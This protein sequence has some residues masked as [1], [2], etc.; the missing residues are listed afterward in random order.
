VLG[1][2]RD[3]SGAVNVT[4][5]GPTGLP[6]VSAEASGQPSERVTRTVRPREEVRVSARR[7]VV[8][9]AVGWVLIPYS[10][11]YDD[12]DFNAHVEPAGRAIVREMS[13][14]CASEPSLLVSV[15]SALGMSA[16]DGV[17]LGDLTGGTLGARLDENKT[18]GPWPM[19]LMLAWGGS[20]E[21]ISPDLQ[22]GYVRDLCAAGV[23]FTWDEYPG[24]THM[25]VLAEDSPLLPHLAAWT[26]DR[27]AGV[28]APASACPPGR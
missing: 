10:E 6:E 7:P 14:R 3:A 24:R 28:P 8:T 20:D 26:D 25:G 13:A 16:G 18:L 4:P 2:R 9:L 5:G 15:V 17:Y 1:E 23:A 19:P 11:A 27:F 21:V 22:H 12:V